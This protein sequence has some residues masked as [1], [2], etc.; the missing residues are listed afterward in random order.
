MIE[1]FQM[2]R[3]EGKSYASAIRNNTWYKNKN[4]TIEWRQ[5]D[6]KKEDV[7]EV[8]SISLTV[9]KEEM[10]W[11]EKGFVIYARNI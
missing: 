3:T 4:Q 10:L 8:A 7:Q 1:R 9:S 6:Y 11:L 5:K 2:I